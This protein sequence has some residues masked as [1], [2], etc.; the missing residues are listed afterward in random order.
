MFSI[1]CW[2]HIRRRGGHRFES[3][4]K[5]R[6]TLKNFSEKSGDFLC[7]N[8]FNY[9]LGSYP[10][11]RRTSVRVSAEEADYL[12]K[13]LREIW[14]FFMRECFQLFAGLLSAEEADIGSSLRRRG[15]LP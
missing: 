10:P 5:R 13:V 2:A 8:V 3:P 9:L 15:G 4:P 12:E 7:V 11:K 1:I 14:G 6:T